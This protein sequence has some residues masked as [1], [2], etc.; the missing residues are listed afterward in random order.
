M[1]LTIMMLLATNKRGQIQP[2]SLP[3]VESQLMGETMVLT[4]EVINA[5]LYWQL[6]DNLE[7]ANIEAT[8]VNRTHPSSIW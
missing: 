8:G 7:R 6:L 1:K 4:E 3:S 5:R 2:M